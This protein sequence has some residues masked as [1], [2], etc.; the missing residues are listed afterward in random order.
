MSV[1]TLFLETKSATLF[2]AGETDELE[3]QTILL[4]VNNTSPIA[5]LDQDGRDLRS[6]QW[7]VWIE[8]SGESNEP[9]GAS[10]GKVTYADGSGGKKYTIHLQ[11]AERNFDALL[12]GIQG[13]EMETDLTVRVR[14]TE[15]EGTESIWRHSSTPALTVASYDF[16]ITLPTKRRDA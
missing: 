10:L 8:R 1:E 12:A 7:A 2:L 4:L 5:L 9:R 13:G 15:T 6:A 14:G 11:V 16:G 3:K